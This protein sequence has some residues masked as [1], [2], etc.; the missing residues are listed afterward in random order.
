MA[1]D[2][3]YR[4][5]Y[6]DY[7]MPRRRSSGMSAVWIVVGIV[8]G[9]IVVIGGGIAL[10]I[11][12]LLMPAVQKVRLAATNAQSGNNMTQLAMAFHDRHDT[13]GYITPSIDS[14]EGKPLLSWRV[15]LLPYLGY[16]QI[17]KQ[18]K[19]DEPWDSANNK[20]LLN[21]MP[22]VYAM[23]G[24]PPNSTT[25][26]YRIFVG[27]GAMFEYKKKTKF[28]LGAP[29][30]DEIGI[31]DGTSNTIMIIEAASAV[32]WTKPDEELNFDPNGPLPALGVPGKERLNF[33]MADGSV[34]GIEV[35]RLN[36]A[37]IKAA[38]T[39]N[40]GEVMQWDW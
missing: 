5:D 40:G 34:H 3:R 4:D 24:D 33:V 16:D 28:N 32:P 22:R 14:K 39:A 11:F 18:F 29:R 20:P 1:R 31:G 13:Y 23:P 26:H 9:V 37:M 27:G 10:L 17:Y 38:I 30:D 6:D 15:E 19:L 35:K 25:T 36:P 8:V 7:D 21:S 2:S 12:G